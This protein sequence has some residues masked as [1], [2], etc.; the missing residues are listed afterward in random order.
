MAFESDPC[1]DLTS[2]ALSEEEGRSGQLKESGVGS[3]ICKSSA[4]FYGKRE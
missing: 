4:I 3:C 1:S 2:G